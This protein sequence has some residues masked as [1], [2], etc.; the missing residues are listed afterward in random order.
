MFF[1]TFDASSGLALELRGSNIFDELLLVGSWY[2]F[3]KPRENYTSE[4]ERK[5]LQTHCHES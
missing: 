4:K 3:C 5:T 2:A 1:Y